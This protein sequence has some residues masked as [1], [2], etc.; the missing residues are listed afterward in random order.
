MYVNILILA[1]IFALTDSIYLTTTSSYYSSVVKNIQ[2]K[3]ITLKPLPTVLCYISL[4]FAVY[5]LI[6]REN[7]SIIQAGLLGFFIYSVF[8]LTNMAI[9]ENWEWKA[10]FLD[11]TWGAILFMI[12]TYIY[13][14]LETFI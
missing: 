5:L 2:G 4:V 9:F 10:V 6:I 14:Q 8:E 3:P 11:S 13:Y 7:K 12:T 1:I